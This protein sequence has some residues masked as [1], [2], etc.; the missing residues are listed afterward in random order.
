MT[1]DI[2][3]TSYGLGPKI[4][5]KFTAHDYLHAQ[6]LRSILITELT[7]MEFTRGEIAA[8]RDAVKSWSVLIS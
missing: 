6:F 3:C 2:F 1:L 7:D 5:K 8:L 4:I